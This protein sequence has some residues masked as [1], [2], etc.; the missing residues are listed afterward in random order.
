MN[1]IERTL[2]Y[3]WDERDPF[4]WLAALAPDARKAFRPNLQLADL[5]LKGDPH[6]PA[7]VPVPGPGAALRP[8]PAGP[9]PE[10]PRPDRQGVGPDPGRVGRGQGP[11]A[12]RLPDPGPGP[13]RPGQGAAPSSSGYTGRL[14]VDPFEFT[15]QDT[16][17]S[18]SSRTGTRSRSWSRP[19]T[20]KRYDGLFKL[21][22]KN[23]GGRLVLDG[24][25]FRLPAG[26]VPAV[27]VLPGGGQLEIRNS[28][29]TLE[30]GEDAGRPPSC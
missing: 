11:A 16:R 18:R 13:G 19:R 30:E 1:D 15:R 20:L 5:R 21:Y 23:G 8:A 17:T 6:G 7:R 22:A 10:P 4:A 14:E 28:V 12:G 3:P 26:R 25:H 9:R 2:K 29:I 27:V 24:L